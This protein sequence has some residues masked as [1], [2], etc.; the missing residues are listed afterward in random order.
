MQLLA[1]IA[2]LITNVLVSLL[3]YQW[4]FLSSYYDPQAFKIDHLKVIFSHVC[5]LCHSVVSDSLQLHEL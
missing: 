2:I 3:V 1:E 5:I 4:R